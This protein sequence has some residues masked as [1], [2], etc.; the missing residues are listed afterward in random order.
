MVRYAA[1]RQIQNVEDLKNFDLEGYAYN[2]AASSAGE[3]VFLR[4]TAA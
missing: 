2:E 4:Q 3:W 1:E